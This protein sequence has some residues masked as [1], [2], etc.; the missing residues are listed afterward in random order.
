MRRAWRVRREYLLPAGLIGE[1]KSAA[2]IAHI[3]LMYRRSEAAIRARNARRP[4][5]ATTGAR[6]SRLRSSEA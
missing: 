5:A 3:V 4:D 2:S 6:R 1:K